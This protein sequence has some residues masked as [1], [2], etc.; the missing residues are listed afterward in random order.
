MVKGRWSRERTA[1][2]NP[3]T[4]AF[5]EEERGEA[6][7]AS[8]DRVEP[9]AVSDDTQDPVRLNSLME[10]VLERTNLKR[11]LHKIQSNRGSRTPGADGMPVHKLAAYLRKHWPKIKVDLESGSYQPFPV[12]RVEIPKP[13]GPARRARLPRDPHDSEQST[14]EA[15]R[16]NKP[17]SAVRKLGIPTALDR[18]MQQAV[19]QVLQPIFD[20]TFSDHSYGFRPGR[21]AHQAVTRSVLRHLDSW[22]RRRL[23]S[24]LWK[25]WK[26]SRVRFAELTS[27]GVSRDLAAQT[28]GNPHGPW[29]LSRS[30]ALNIALPNSLWKSLGL[31]T[32]AR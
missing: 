23:R 10:A 14:H 24:L 21:S 32:L 2:E 28:C 16:H 29:H 18:F 30:P 31:P 27:R 19:L 5:P 12:K 11:A 7:R 1:T 13:G 15:K 22:L 3:V 9:C 8:G 20:P 6:S 17:P 4:L 25:R 26:I